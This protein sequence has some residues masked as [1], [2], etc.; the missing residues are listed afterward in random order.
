M[1]E[2]VR[3]TEK[4][5]DLFAHLDPYNMLELGRLP[6]RVCLGSVQRGENGLNDIPAGL[7]V[8]RLMKDALV[9]EWIYVDGSCRY[10]CI[11][12]GLMRRA[13]EEAQ[14]RGFEDIYAYIVPTDK[15]SVICSGEKEFLKDYY[16]RLLK[17]GKTNSA[18]FK[19]LIPEQYM[20]ADLYSTDI[21]GYFETM[22]GFIRQA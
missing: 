1:Y 11:G 12:A 2:T 15:R 21:A 19:K 13:F 18:L 9:I 7:M 14:K 22:A 16:F 20:G 4:V 3:L 5:L 8:C 10:Q 6:D 17:P